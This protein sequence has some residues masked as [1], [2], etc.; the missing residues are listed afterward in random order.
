M[1]TAICSGTTS[2]GVAAAA[3]RPDG[4]G[5]TAAETLT[6]ARR[7]AKLPVPLTVDISTGSLLFRA[8]LAAAD[9]VRAGGLAVPQGLPS[10]AEVQGPVPA[11]HCTKPDVPLPSG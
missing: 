7:L 2:L 5:A 4:I 11:K 10:Y 6:L 8:A 1:I 3:G 9:G